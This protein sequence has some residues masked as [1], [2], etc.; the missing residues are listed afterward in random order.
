MTTGLHTVR[1]VMCSK[2]GET[3]GWKYGQSSVFRVR[4]HPPPPLFVL[5]LMEGVKLIAG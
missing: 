4:T 2:C 3:L 5:S 1:D